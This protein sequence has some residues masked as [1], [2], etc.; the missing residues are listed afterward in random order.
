M[1]IG[2]RVAKPS[3][4]GHRIVRL[5]CR[6][7]AAPLIVWGIVALILIVYLRPM[8]IRDT[9]LVS[10]MPPGALPFC[11]RNA[12]DC[13][14]AP[15]AALTPDAF[16]GLDRLNYAVNHAIIPEMPQLT[17]EHSINYWQV[18]PDGGAGPC[19]D[20]ALT[21]R[22]RLIAQGYPAGAFSI[23]VVHSDRSPDDIFHAVL[24]ARLGN[25]LYVLDNLTNQVAPLAERD[26][27]KWIS[28]S[29][30]GD[31]WRWKAGAPTLP[32]AETAQQISGDSGLRGSAY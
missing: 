14:Q 3:H 13:H 24:V 21:K 10:V 18:L 32:A 6:A 7:V 2:T 1:T 26:D 9:E 22:H 17:A 23:A 30:F 15:P 27:L 16:T 12:Q 20:Y 31:M 25:A 11:I 29:A 19:I 4:D 8:K 28:H 5:V